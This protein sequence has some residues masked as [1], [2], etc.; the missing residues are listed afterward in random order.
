MK[1]VFV[2]DARR[3]IIEKVATNLIPNS[4]GYVSVPELGASLVED[5]IVIPTKTKLMLLLNQ[6][7]NHSVMVMQKQGIAHHARNSQHNVDRLS[8]CN[9]AGKTLKKIIIWANYVV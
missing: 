1:L 9:M 3:I 8:L 7:V 5:S 4:I 6:R 2:D